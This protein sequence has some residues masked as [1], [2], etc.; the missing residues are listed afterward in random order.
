MNGLA[1]ALRALLGWKTRA[2]ALQAALAALPRPAG[3]AGTRPGEARVAAVQLRARAYRSVGDFAAHLDV[4]AG[5]AAAAGAKLAVFPE[6]VATGLLGLL[7]GFERLAAGLLATGGAPGPGPRPA[8]VLALAGPYVERAYRRIFAGLAARHRLTIVAGTA[9]V[10]RDGR[11]FNLCHVFAP[12]GQLAGVQAKCHLFPHEEAW[13]IAAGDDL[14]AWPTPAGKLAVAVC[15]DATYFETFRIARSL[16]AELVA[17]PSA[18]PDEYNPWKE[19]RGAW[20]R[21]QESQVYAVRACLVGELA[22]FR[23]SGRSAV[24]APL[25]LSPRGDGVLAQVDDPLGE[26]LAV[27]PL[28]LAALAQLR[29]RQALAAPG[30]SVLA[31]LLAAYGTASTPNPAR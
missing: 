4:W 9:L 7:P 17:V 2:A 21:V 14:T 30:S 27:A 31:S 19:R 26:G 5:R 28:D 1:L 16:G 18:D 6:D 22:G 15:M 25:E 10:P 20:A 23:L 24:Y 11:V 8:D 13:G 3:A 29:R 12:S